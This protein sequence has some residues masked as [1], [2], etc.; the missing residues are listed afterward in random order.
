[1]M[2]KLT[3]L[4]F[5]MLLNFFGATAQ[6]SYYEFQ[7]N[8]QASR[9]NA[10]YIDAIEAQARTPNSPYVRTGID[11]SVFDRPVKVV[12]EE[13]QER[14]AA[15]RKKA[16][17]D[18]KAEVD[19]IIA[20]YDAIDNVAAFYNT[21]K[22]PILKA[23]IY[24]LASLSITK[25]ATYT[26]EYENLLEMSAYVKVFNDELATAKFE[27]L[28]QTIMQYQILSLTAIESVNKLKAK[29]PER[30]FETDLLTVQL[31][32]G[33]FYGISFDKSYHNYYSYTNWIKISDQAPQ[34][35]E[36]AN[37]YTSIYKKYPKQVGDLIGKLPD[38]SKLYWFLSKFFYEQN[39][40]P[41]E[42]L[43]KSIFGEKLKPNKDAEEVK[44]L[45][46]HTP[47]YLINTIDNG[48]YYEL[49]KNLDTAVYGSQI[50]YL[51]RIHASSKIVA[52]AI[53][54]CINQIIW[55]MQK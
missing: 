38:F 46:L 35:V 12:T 34:W 42:L 11:R 2:Q 37:L 30:E 17:A 16:A 24:R 9:N 52:K 26:Q 39:M 27:D 40:E 19:K 13:E 33:F 20:K 44:Y 48:F 10:A 25:E 5:F 36:M 55:R 32:P 1:M 22:L 43:L 6:P 21:L 18:L 51:G 49:I 47:N 53:I 15:Y 23:D 8:L 3:L 28:V 54:N 29:F 14:R 41:K 7:R 50:A 4:S 45:F 31:L